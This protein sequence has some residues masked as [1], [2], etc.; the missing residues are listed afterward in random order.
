[1]KKCASREAA[2]AD[3][4]DL[5][6]N[7]NAGQF[8]VLNAGIFNG[9]RARDSFKENQADQICPVVSNLLKF[10]GNPFLISSHFHDVRQMM[11]P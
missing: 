2:V 10:E 11:P 6:R 8:A 1:L 4:L 9:S 5:R 7:H 3:A